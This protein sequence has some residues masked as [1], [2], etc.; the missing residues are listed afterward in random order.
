MGGFGGNLTHMRRAALPFSLAGLILAVAS[1]GHAQQ[2]TAASGSKAAPKKAA[3][4]P[5]LTMPIQQRRF[6][7]AFE[8]DV[9]RH[10]GL[11]E[12][13]AEATNP[14]GAALVDYEKPNFEQ[15]FRAQEFAI[16]GKGAFENWVGYAMP[17]VDDFRRAFLQVRFP[18]KWTET[19]D[20][21]EQSNN[22]YLTSKTAF[23]LTT[24]EAKELA[25]LKPGDKVFVSGSLFCG[26]VTAFVASGGCESDA[27]RNG[28]EI[29]RADFAI[30]RSEK[31]GVVARVGKDPD[32]KPELDHFKDVDL[33]RRAKITFYT[34]DSLETLQ[35]KA[36]AL[37]AQ[38]PTPDSMKL[39]Q[40][41]LIAPQCDRCKDSL[42]TA[43]F[44]VYEANADGRVA[45][46]QRS[47]E[48]AGKQQI[49]GEMVTA[50]VPSDFPGLKG[51]NVPVGKALFVP[52]K[53]GAGCAAVLTY[54]LK[55]MQDNMQK[56]DDRLKLL[57][58]QLVQ[59][60]SPPKT[61]PNIC[62]A[63]NGTESKREADVEDDKTQREDA[64]KAVSVNVVANDFGAM[65][66]EAVK[67]KT[68]QLGLDAALYEQA[69]KQV[70]DLVRLCSSM[71]GADYAASIDPYGTAR[72]GSYKSGV[73]KACGSDQ[74]VPPGDA[75]GFVVKHDPG[76]RFDG[77]Q[78]LWFSSSDHFDVLL[79]PS[80]GERFETFYGFD[81][82]Y[83]TLSANVV[84]PGP[85]AAPR[86]VCPGAKLKTP[87]SGEDV[88][89]DGQASITK[90]TYRQAN[91]NGAVSIDL[92]EPK[93]MIYNTTPDQI[94]NSCGTG[95]AAA[96]KSP[97]VIATTEVITTTP[98]T[99]PASPP[100]PP[101][102][103]GHIT[104]RVK[105]CS[106]DRL[107]LSPPRGN[108]V[109]GSGR[110]LG[111]TQVGDEAVILQKGDLVSKVEIQTGEQ[112]VGWLS[113]DAFCTA[114]SAE[115]PATAALENSV[116][117]ATAPSDEHTLILT[118]ASPLA[119][120]A[121]TIVAPPNGFQK[122]NVYYIDTTAFPNGGTLDIEITIAANSR[123]DGSFNLFPPNFPIPTRGRPDG[124]LEG[125][126]D[127][128]RGTSARFAYRF[129]SGQV[130][131]LGLEG[132]W[133]SPAGSAGSVTFRA[134]VRK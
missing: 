75:P 70:S 91:K 112:K 101:S 85:V 80:K 18:C 56:I 122:F 36:I 10:V 4:E 110:L 19:W 41:L 1:I 120:R 73:Y 29:I 111:M 37:V 24:P 117:A 49:C 95:G 87:L 116:P 84:R 125:R 15:I 47:C 22:L 44:E 128:R 53:D 108:S 104:S 42:G 67:T 59:P 20:N 98:A 115:P 34:T 78:R 97:A 126:Y 46:K 35:T 76:K 6:C 58:T 72:L 43:R 74:V 86:Y 60:N 32:Y 13:K 65:L 23:E 33:L 39:L 55:V 26:P 21:R 105:I 50:V 89:F 127:V 52:T 131:A 134:S 129:R 123:T 40:F 48:I 61:P 9:A 38:K 109:A 27:Y 118:P 90:I 45:K 99:T 132:N 31:N 114:S 14:I 63:I 7:A 107:F 94:K 121:A 57:G 25:K 103:S 17:A 102:T 8:E 62:N 124:A 71:S 5:P 130:F 81:R 106:R 88:T 92:E 51:L 69:I 2:R 54:E 64:L 66:T 16:M 11:E 83:I 3:A 79:K 96:D 93:R 28:K 119:E 113:N 100:P 12:K 30:I 82:K 68:S 133:F 77:L